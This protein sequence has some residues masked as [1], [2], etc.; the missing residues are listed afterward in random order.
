MAQADHVAAARAVYDASGEDYV[1]F[2]GTEISAA[3]EGPID[4]ALLVAFAELV[5]AAPGALVAD[6]GCGPGRAAAFLAAQGLEVVGVDV[7]P[8]MLAAARSAHPEIRFEEGRLD[9]LPIPEG[10]L[11]GVVCWYSIIYTPPGHL[12]EVFAEVARVLTPGG[13]VMV[14]FQAGTGQPERRPDA[15]GTGLPLTSY[16][17]AVDD[18]ARR[19]AAAGLEVRSCA[20]RKAELP[21]ESSPQAFLIARAAGHSS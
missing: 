19:L 9:G 21:H 4:R 3:T 5:A 6:V 2:V 8:V 12:D 13:H 1:K 20:H 7:S 14:A 16:R 11:A 18:V 17:H 15:H 10:S